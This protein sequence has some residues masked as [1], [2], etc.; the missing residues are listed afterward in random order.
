MMHARP[1]M[2]A[3]LQGLGATPDFCLRTLQ[4][5][6]SNNGVI[7][8]SSATG[9]ENP[10]TVAYLTRRFGP[11]Y[12]TFPGGNCGMLLEVQRTGVMVSGPVIPGG[13]GISTGVLLIGA[14]V[15]AGIALIAF[16]R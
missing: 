3:P 4:Y 9:T 5:L 13:G 10:E 12:R 8:A 2:M 1:R 6:L 14:A 7:P 11:S 16:R 15:I